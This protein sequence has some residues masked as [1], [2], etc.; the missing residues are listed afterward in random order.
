MG[1]SRTPAKLL[2]RDLFPGRVYK[3]NFKGKNKKT[4]YRF[5]GT[6][7]DNDAR[8]GYTF[9]QLGGKNERLTWAQAIVTRFIDC[10]V[11]APEPERAELQ[12]PIGQPISPL[13]AEEQI[14][15]KTAGESGEVAST[16]ATLTDPSGTLASFR[17]IEK[18][19]YDKLDEL[20]DD[21]QALTRR[22]EDELLPIVDRAQSYLSIQGS[23]HVPGIGLPPWPEWRD[24]FLRR[25]KIKMSPA[26]CN[27]S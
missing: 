7:W 9:Q 2:A 3:F 18:Q 4:P 12:E 13:A 21:F 25:L 20:A 10:E 16:D 11:V 15:Q 8:E 22:F 1:M 26:N 24:A 17:E 23:M 19:V 6:T 27:A 14:S 5:E